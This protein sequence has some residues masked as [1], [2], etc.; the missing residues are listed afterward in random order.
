[1][2]GCRTVITG[3]RVDV[4]R[5]MISLGSTFDKDTKTFGTLQQALSIYLSGTVNK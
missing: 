3:L 2:M 4:V 1:M 5:K